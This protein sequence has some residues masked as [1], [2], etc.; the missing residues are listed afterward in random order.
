MSAPDIITAP[1]AG[2]DS[3]T[4]GSVRAYAMACARRFE[5]AADIAQEAQQTE[6]ATL[7]SMAAIA[8]MTIAQRIGSVRDHV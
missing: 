4:R 7:A 8:F 6:Q 1:I 2:S 3:Q 5:T